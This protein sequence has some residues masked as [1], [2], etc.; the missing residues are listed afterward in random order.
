MSKTNDP[1]FLNDVDF[2]E[3]TRRINKRLINE[4]ETTNNIRLAQYDNLRTR[5]SNMVNHILGI[6]YYNDAY[7]VYECDKRCC[8]HIITKFDELELKYK[9]WRKVGMNSLFVA[10]TA[11]LSTICLVLQ[12]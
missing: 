4:K 12:L 6:N 9:F 10:L 2:L 3:Y 5:F 11:L 8:E 7:D 1:S